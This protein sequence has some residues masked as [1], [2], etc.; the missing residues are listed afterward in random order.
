M[1]IFV[2][3]KGSPQPPESNPGSRS[4][5]GSPQVSYSSLNSTYHYLAPTHIEIDVHS[6]SSLKCSRNSLS[7]FSNSN[8]PCL[9]NRSLSPLSSPRRSPHLKRAKSWREEKQQRNKERRASL[10]P[11][12]KMNEYNNYNNFN[13]NNNNIHSR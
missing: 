1:K 12:L 4:N 7:P 5:L 13:N 6:P 11:N 9:S 2:I 8:S 3:M 10:S